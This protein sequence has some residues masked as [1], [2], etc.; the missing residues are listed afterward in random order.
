M[1][2]ES[3][4]QTVQEDEFSTGKWMTGSE[5]VILSLLEEGVD[6][7]FGYPGGAI[8]P[9]YDAMYHYEDRIRHILTRHD[10]RAWSEQPGDM[11]VGCHDG[12]FTNGLHYWPGAQSSFGD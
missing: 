3:A 4:A 12:F 9:I 6:V 5:A 7:I 8:M 2:E 11:A 10:F 1:S